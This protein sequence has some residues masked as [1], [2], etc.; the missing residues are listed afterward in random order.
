VRANDAAALDKV[1]VLLAIFRFPVLSVGLQ[2]VLAAEPDF[3]MVGGAG[4]ESLVED[5]RTSGADVVVCECQFNDAAGCSTFASIEAIKAACPGVKVIALECRCGAEQFSLALK[6]GA[7]GFLTREASALDVVA[8]VRG[9]VAGHTYVSPAIV[10]RMVNTYVLH[11]PDGDVADTYGTLSERER[12]VLL[13]AAMGQTTRQIAESL[14]LSEQTIHNY[15][16]DFMEKLGLH[17]RVELL[18]YAIRR[19]ILN[20]ADL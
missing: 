9:V 1:V 12:E 15:R 13:L 17:D 7:D 14:H 4:P 2:T 11:L 5:V 16:S 8:A 10:T 20:A 18:R 19:G 3:C 6:A